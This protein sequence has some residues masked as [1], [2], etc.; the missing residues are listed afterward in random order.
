LDTTGEERARSSAAPY[1]LA[2]GSD[3]KIHL[4]E[5]GAKN[6]RALLLLLFNPELA[7]KT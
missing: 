6:Q 5:R 7:V 1:K 3:G 2:R 4:Q